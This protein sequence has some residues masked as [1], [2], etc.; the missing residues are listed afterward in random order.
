VRCESGSVP[1]HPSRD[2]QSQ[3]LWYQDAIIYE[4]HVRAFFDSDEANRKKL[5]ILERLAAEAQ[6]G[7]SDKHGS[8]LK[9]LRQHLRGPPHQKPRGQGTIGSLGGIPYRL[10][11]LRLERNTQLLDTHQPILPW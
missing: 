11:E 9:Q 3:S 2:A 8:L 10:S 5:D 7:T 1:L 6:G 4:T